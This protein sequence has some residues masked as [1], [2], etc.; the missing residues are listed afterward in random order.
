MS[1]T[2]YKDGMLVEHPN[3]PDWGPGK[4]VHVEAQKVHV[5]FRDVPERTAKAIRFDVVPLKVAASQ[6]DPILDNLPPLTKEGSD[7]VLPAERKTFDQAVEEFSRNFPG[8]F[9]DPGYLGDLKSGERVYKWAAHE[10]W[11]E[12][13]G[14]DQARQLLE[15]DLGELTR[16][17]LS[18]VSHVNLLAPKYEQA[19]MREA[20]GDKNA[21]LKFFSTLLDLLEAESPNQ[22]AFQPYADAVCALPVK[23]GGSRVSTWPVATI[24]PFLA[25]PDRQMLLK[26]KVTH[27]AANTLAFDLRYDAM[28]NWKTYDALLRMSRTY[29]DLLKPRGA[30]DFIDVQSFFWVVGYYE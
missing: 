22:A 20:L 23:P 11:T 25:Q 27:K 1:E 14:G 15:T 26:P 17:A 7:W 9:E 21:A 13:L 19:P 24:L 5:V 10:R 4:I 18:V 30:R 6:S 12:T 8:G 2:P 29:F 16:R 3:M 28:P